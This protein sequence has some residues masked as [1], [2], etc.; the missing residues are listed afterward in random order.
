MS[1]LQV[2]RGQL[3]LRRGGQGRWCG[4]HL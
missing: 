2:R 3:Q 4:G 1:S